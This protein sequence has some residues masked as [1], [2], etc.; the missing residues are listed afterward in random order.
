MCGASWPDGRG[1]PH[2]YYAVNGQAMTAQQLQQ[3]YACPVCYADIR[4]RMVDGELAILCGGPDAHD[5]EAL[6]RAIE[7]GKRDYAIARQEVDAVD[8]L[9]GLKGAKGMIKDLQK[10]VGPRLKRAG[11][12]RLGYKKK[13]A[14]G[15]EYP[16]AADHFVLRDAPDVA[17]IYTDKPTRLNIYLPFNEVHRNLVAWHQMWQAG[18]LICRGDGEQIEYAVAHES[19]EV[20]V[21][22]GKALIDSE[23]EKISLSR[24]ESVP[25]PGME[26]DLYPRCLDCKPNAMLIII[27]RE[28]PR[29]AYYQISTTSIHNIV[30]LTGQMRW[31]KENVG[32]LQGVPFILELRPEK[33]STP[34]Q[35]GK[36]VRRE[37]YLLH[38]EPDPEWV[39]AMLA[40][41][42]KRA[43]PGSEVAEKLAIPAEVGAVSDLDDEPVWEPHDYHDDDQVDDAEFYEDEERVPEPT[44]DLEWAAGVTTSKGTP[45][46]EL[47]ADQLMW[48]LEQNNGVKPEQ[49]EAAG[50]LLDAMIDAGDDVAVEVSDYGTTLTGDL[51]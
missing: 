11:I 44:R 33:I 13:N 32:R 24:G 16:V 28:I 1:L 6:G 31:V 48:I 18:G 30:N 5:I 34:G 45:F 23:V 43:L 40:E 29:L 3:A 46:G 9:Y 22:S 35:N 49:K 47:N 4:P 41:M 42:H 2:G 39:R 25:C 38:L 17:S 27:V 37:K 8:V 20:I 51:E 7:K 21:K 12:I 19:G 26:H 36:R 15:K 10:D 14:R 50:L